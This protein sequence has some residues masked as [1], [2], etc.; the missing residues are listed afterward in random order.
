MAALSEAGLGAGTGVSALMTGGGPVSCPR[1]EIT[2]HAP[3]ASATSTTGIA[4]QTMG[5]RDAGAVATLVGIGA[6]ISG[7]AFCAAEFGTAVVGSLAG[8]PRVTM[9]PPIDRIQPST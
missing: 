5:E 6:G 7:A 9:P 8:L 1:C 4:I 3:P 2:N